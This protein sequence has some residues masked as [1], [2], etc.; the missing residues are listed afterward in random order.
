MFAAICWVITLILAALAA[1]STV[2]D[3]ARATSAPQ[4]AAAAA[5]GIVMVVIPYVFTRAVQELSEASRRRQERERAIVAARFAER[6]SAPAP[7]PAATVPAGNPDAVREPI[8]G[9]DAK[10]T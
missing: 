2:A 7:Q 5:M 1:A 3:L 4:Q 10:L 9:R 8:Y 6:Q